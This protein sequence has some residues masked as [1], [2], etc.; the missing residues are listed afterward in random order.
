M[1]AAASSSVGIESKN[2]LSRK[3]LK[4][5]ATDGSQIAHGVFSRLRCTNGRLLAVRYVGRMSTVVGIISVASIANSTTF[6]N[7]GR[8]LEKAYAAATSKT[9]CRASAPAA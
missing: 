7:T 3:T 1:A 4:A 8:S 6:P 2:L 9:S 5:L